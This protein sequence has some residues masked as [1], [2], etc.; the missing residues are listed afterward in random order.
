MPFPRLETRCPPRA[1]AGRL[2]GSQASPL[3]AMAGKRAS[4]L[5]SGAAR[6]PRSGAV[7][8]PLALRAA[9]SP[10]RSVYRTRRG[11]AS[12]ATKVEWADRVRAGPRARRPRNPPSPTAYP[13]V[14][15]RGFPHTGR[16][17]RAV[18]PKILP[19]SPKTRPTAR[20]KPFPNYS[21]CVRN[22]RKVFS[23]ISKGGPF[24][25]R[26]LSRSESSV[27]PIPCGS[28]QSSRSSSHRD[29]RRR[30]DDVHVEHSRWSSSTARTS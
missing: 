25:E 5:V 20:L 24:G 11:S 14:L 30:Q 9:A 19:V 12:H 29:S 17:E 23:T 8:S 4:R 15:N 21:K 16:Y 10:Q 6:L 22:P 2:G 26:Y 28:T 3:E 13:Q 7:G 27:T 1:I 18:K